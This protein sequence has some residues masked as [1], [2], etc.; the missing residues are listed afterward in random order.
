MPR[1]PSS[2]SSRTNSRRKCFCSKSSSIT[3]RMRSCAKRRARCCHSRSSS[4]RSASRSNTASMRG[5][6]TVIMGPSVVRFAGASR[7]RRARR[8]RAAGCGIGGGPASRPIGFAIERWGGRAVVAELDHGLEPEGLGERE[9]LGHVVHEPGGHARPREVVD[10]VRGGCRGERGLDRLVQLVAVRDPVGVRREPGVVGEAGCAEHA[11]E[12]AELL[13][14]AHGDHE[15]AV[16]GAEHRVRRDRRVR[17]AHPARRRAGRE[18]RGRLVRERRE[19]ALQQVHLDEL[20][21]AGAVAVAQREEDPGERVLPG[22][23]VDEGDADLARA[24]RRARR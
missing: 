3:G 24:R 11:R 8:A 6:V 16:G 13:V 15:L 2:P 14:V 21:H 20:A 5:A 19:Q 9:G 4:S 1:N 7:R 10:P 22:E 17:V 18:R 12:R 23:H